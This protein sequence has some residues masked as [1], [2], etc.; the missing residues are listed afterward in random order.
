MMSQEIEKVEYII[1][2]R[3]N[4]VRPAEIGLP[5][6]QKIVHAP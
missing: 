6:A 3:L 5:L 1:Q 2:E 4:F